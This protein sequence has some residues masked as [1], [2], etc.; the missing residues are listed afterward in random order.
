M[1]CFG[2]EQVGSEVF[3]AAVYALYILYILLVAFFSVGSS[4]VVQIYD[5]FS[6]NGWMDGWMGNKAKQGRRY[7]IFPPLIFYPL[8]GETR[9]NR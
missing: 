3:V 5:I 9:Q 7:G 1:L 4:V 2:A 6:N 8:R